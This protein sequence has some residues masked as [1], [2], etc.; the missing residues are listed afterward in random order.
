MRQGQYHKIIKMVLVQ[1]LAFIGQRLGAFS[2]IENTL[3]E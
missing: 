1:N 3:N 2:V